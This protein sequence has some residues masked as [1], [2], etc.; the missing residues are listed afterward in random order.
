MRQS[1][2]A[3]IKDII[4]SLEQAR[5]EK[6]KL[7]GIL[8]D[9]DKQTGLERTL[10][11]CENAGV[12][13]ILAGGSLLTQG[14]LDSLLRKIKGISKIPVIIFPGNAM[15]VSPLA[16]AIFLLSLISGRNPEFLIGQH[17]VA[18]PQIIKSGIE[19][20][21]TGYML[22]DGG[23]Y[24][25]ASYMSNTFP[26]PR[27]KDDIAATVASAG[28]LL[29]LKTI[30][31]DAGSGADFPVSESMIRAVHQRVPLPIVA[32]G[33]IGNEIDAARAWNAG[34]TMVICGTGV[35]NSPD[36]IFRLAEVRESL[37]TA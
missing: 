15:Q 28:W 3:V 1:F 31:L 27:D 29:G 37:Q 33:G 10:T 35:E 36:F 17:V 19:V 6:R 11:T 20:I 21:P 12:D 30:Y 32:G 24:T 25:T 2:A 22:V 5:I 18:A 7:L 34:A 26:L 4:N 8:I 23:K 16:D 14:N 13:Y 9:P